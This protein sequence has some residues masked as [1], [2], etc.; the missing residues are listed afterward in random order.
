MCKFWTVH[1]GF[2]LYVTILDLSYSIWYVGNN[3]TIHHD[4]H[5]GLDGHDSFDC[6]DCQDCHDGHDNMII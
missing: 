4:G 5:N 3:V 6:H 1:N 2:R